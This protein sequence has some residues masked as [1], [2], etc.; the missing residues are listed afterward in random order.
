MDNSSKSFSSST[1]PSKP[2]PIP[3]GGDKENDE[4]S[5]ME[6]NVKAPKNVTGTT[7]HFMTPTISAASK[8]T[9]PRKKILA[10][11]NESVDTHSQETPIS[12]SK[13]SYSDESAD[14]LSS[15]P[16]DPLT[17]Y[18]SPR[19]RFLRYN[20]NRRREILLHRENGNK[21]GEFGSSDGS[22]SGS[23]LKSNKGSDVEEGDSSSSKDSQEDN[24]ELEI[25]ELVDSEDEFEDVEEKRG[26][27]FTTVLK[28]LLLVAVLVLST[29]YISSM[30]SSTPSPVVQA[31]VGLTDG[32][33]MIQDHVYGYVNSVRSGNYSWLEREEAELG[34][35]YNV[36]FEKEMVPEE[37][38]MVE[39]E[40]DGAVI[41]VEEAQ[42]IEAFE[43]VEEELEKEVYGF[44]E[45]SGISEQEG[46]N[47]G[48][49]I[50]ENE[51]KEDVVEDEEK[52]T[53]V[54]VLAAHSVNLEERAF[55]GEHEVVTIGEASCDQVVVDPEVKETEA[56]EV[57]EISPVLVVDNQDIESAAPT[58]FSSEIEVA[59]E[60]VMEEEIVDTEMAILERTSDDYTSQE[61]N[62]VEAV[63]R[64]IDERLI[65][66]M[67]T[68][69]IVK[70]VIGISLVSA[71]I[72]SLALACRS[73]RK[74]ISV[75]E[76]RFVPKVLK[77]RTPATSQSEP[78]MFSAN[79]RSVM[80][81]KSISV[82][83]NQEAGAAG[84]IHPFS[85]F[86]NPRYLIKSVEEEPKEMHQRAPS[87][88]FLGEFVVREMGSLLISCGAKSKNIDGEMSSHSVPIKKETSSKAPSVSAGHV[89]PDVSEISIA[90]SESQRRSTTE[91]KTVKSVERATSPLTPLRRSSRIRNRS[92]TSP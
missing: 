78:P 31:V 48:S 59:S 52:G 23:D 85:S 74:R 15:K 80:A 16:Y 66:F 39:A 21:E 61:G 71:F 91:K 40:T 68:E 81:E 53:A 14:E 18:L 36:G 47:K 13:P 86:S 12:Y 37:V 44:G 25:E 4:N 82:V 73:K 8:V 55:C 32:Y 54:D 19:P 51:G 5:Q 57:S 30:N 22:G 6:A 75:V 41:E 56:A 2:P 38:D 28:H 10:E 27:G 65:E 88:E 72:A 3:Q 63:W 17:N 64:S 87:V 1:P 90:N 49:L 46:E 7:K 77:K 50:V 34:F 43:V 62:I 84:H 60:S 24:V 35:T 33:R 11:R 29:A 42:S 92:V 58:G 69:P 76:H 20:P 26:W 79:S 70:A 45:Y 83:D 89:Q 67:E 9:P